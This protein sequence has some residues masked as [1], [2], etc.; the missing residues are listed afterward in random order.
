[1]RCS[2]VR[3]RLLAYHDGDLSSPERERLQTHLNQCSLC[4]Q[5]WALYQRALA[6]LEKSFFLV[7]PGDLWPS[8]KAR[9]QRVPL[10]GWGWARGALA[11][12]VVGLCVLSGFGLL[13]RSGTPEPGPVS[14]RL[15]PEGKHYA[16]VPLTPRKTLGA[17]AKEET[18][19]P[20]LETPIPSPISP[21]EGTRKSPETESTTGPEVGRATSVGSPP[22]PSRVGKRKRRNPRRGSSP[23][24][25]KAQK[26]PVA[27]PSSAPG[28]PEDSEEPGDGEKREPGNEDPKPDLKPQDKDGSPDKKL[29]PEE[30]LE[31]D[32]PPGSYVLAVFYPPDPP[33]KREPPETDPPP[34]WWVVEIPSPSLYQVALT[35]NQG[36][37][38]QQRVAQTV[39][40]E[41]L[42]AQVEIELIGPKPVG[43][44][45]PQEENDEKLDSIT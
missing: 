26:I 6:A 31:P 8:F 20:S 40:P 10:R 13:R 5:E 12:V 37:V 19:I 24:R 2:Q 18:S 21:S 25:R 11:L 36:Q 4:Q 43:P 3:K 34:G 9:Q 39:D 23:R 22:S 30:E 33:E 32:W 38:S 17:E 16:S 45:A 28:S 14:H 35:D 41:T 15:S 42:T 29:P 27:I 44:L 7:D 1:M